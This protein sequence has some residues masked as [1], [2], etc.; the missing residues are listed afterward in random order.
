MIDQTP[1]SEN[2]PQPL[3]ACLKTGKGYQRGVIPPFEKGR[4]GGILQQIL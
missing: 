3:F 1:F 2:L 4:R